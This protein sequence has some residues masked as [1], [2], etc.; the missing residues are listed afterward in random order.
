MEADAF[1]SEELVDEEG[2][3]ELPEQAPGRGSATQMDDDGKYDHFARKEAPWK[4]SEIL[5][6]DQDRRYQLW[7]IGMTRNAKADQRTRTRVYLDPIPHILKD[8]NIPI[9]GWY[10]SKFETPGVRDRP[11][12]LPGSLVD[13]PWGPR[14]I[15]TLQVGDTVLGY[16]EETGRY[17]STYVE[18]TSRQIK[19]EYLELELENGR[20]LKLTED[21]PVYVKNRGWVEAGRLQEGDDILDIGDRDIQEIRKQLE[22]EGVVVS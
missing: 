16:D 13:T 10:K 17:A 12:L 3:P 20:V 5:T 2:F 7:D 1:L 18:A 14:P 21:H 15:E 22:L 6:D 4:Q 9:R 19:E 8:Q 11:C